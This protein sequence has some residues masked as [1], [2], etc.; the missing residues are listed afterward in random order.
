M[1]SHPYAETVRKD[2][3]PA[4]VQASIPNVAGFGSSS[5]GGGLIQTTSG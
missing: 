4:A 1:H 2:D 5:A 3:T